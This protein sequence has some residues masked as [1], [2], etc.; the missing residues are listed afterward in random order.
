LVLRPFI[1]L[2][3]FLGASGILVARSGFVSESELFSRVKAATGGSKWDRVMAIQW[4]GQVESN[5][6]KGSESTIEHLGTG[7]WIHRRQLGCLSGAD[8]F[9]GQ[10]AWEQD[11]SGCSQPL[12]S[13]MGRKETATAA[14]MVCRGPFFRERWGAN[15]G[16]VRF[17]KEAGR[18]FW[19]A[20]IEPKGGNPFTVWVDARTW[21]IA[22]ILMTRFG[23]TET[24][25][26]EDYREVE[27]LVVPATVTTTS[28]GEVQSIWRLTRMR[29]NP[30]V[31]PGTF[32]RPVGLPLDFG[33][34]GDSGS[35]RLPMA[36]GTGSQIFLRASLNGRGPF[37]F[38]LDSGCSTSGL[39]P[40]TAQEVG[41][42]L[43]G[44]A[45]ETGIGP[46][47]GAIAFCRV[48]R[49]QLGPAWMKDQVFTV[50]KGLEVLGPIHGEPCAGILGSELFKRFVV[51]L[52]YVRREATLILPGAFRPP[53]GRPGLP[54]AF[55]QGLPQVE[56]ELDGRKGALTLDT[57][58]EESL[59]VFASFVQR[60]RL[61]RRGG[62]RILDPDYVGIGGGSVS[63]A[64]R[65]QY[66]RVGHAV[67]TRPVISLNV[68]RKGV[69]SWMEG[70]GSLGGGFLERFHVTFDYPRERVFLEP[71]ANA[72]RPDVF[73][74]RHGL[75]GLQACG[76]GLRIG[77]IIP[78]S[79]AS[80]AGLRPGDVIV[81]LGP[82]TGPGLNLERARIQLRGDPG[83]L[84]EM[85]V[86]RGRRCIRARFW[87]RDL[88]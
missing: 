8:G 7:A 67:M 10:E 24:T 82:W 36:A 71:N 27:G 31:G 66:I 69:F 13:T 45:R 87:L 42:T 40:G 5:G 57:G 73:R 9:D 49:L 62:K 72:D 63:F 11:H 41:L 83:T 2:G 53:E 28:R 59:D 77:R 78:G 70:I 35:V 81:A 4:W 34:D 85:A 88:L 46:E 32:A 12:R 54:L 15:A 50:S 86:L 14:F 30:E 26:L 25:H 33:L 22:R 3:V 29:L 23:R 60:H 21:R 20:R 56:G 1:M 58:S 68:S 61:L 6:W 76:K 17:R 65:G 55:W 44:V 79:P 19:V 52:D 38:C 43:Q 39:T 75:Q 48:D 37:W 84:V 51:S 47:E 18:P 64:T 16:P 74:N 80:G